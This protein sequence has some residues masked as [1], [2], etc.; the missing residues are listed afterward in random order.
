MGE[1]PTWFNI[2][3]SYSGTS[4]NLKAEHLTVIDSTKIH[5]I[6]SHHQ[7]IHSQWVDKKG[8]IW[9]GNQPDFLIHMGFS[10]N[11]SLKPINWHRNFLRLLREKS[12]PHRRLGDLRPRQLRNGLFQGARGPGIASATGFLRG[13]GSFAVKILPVTR[14]FDAKFGSYGWWFQPTPLKNRNVNCDD[15]S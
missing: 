12:H 13:N 15:C 8:N 6:H 3:H 9:T 4:S 10:C 7:K 14:C 11:F 5:G 2:I 1:I